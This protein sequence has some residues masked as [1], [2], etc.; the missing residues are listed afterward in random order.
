MWS[1]SVA[2]ARR[3]LQRMRLEAG[4][5]A[6]GNVAWRE[7]WKHGVVKSLPV[8]RNAARL[9][10]LCVARRMP[11]APRKTAARSARLS[12]SSCRCD[13]GVGDRYAFSSH[14]CESRFIAS[15]PRLVFHLPRLPREEEADRKAAR[16]WMRSTRAMDPESPLSSIDQTPLLIG[17]HC[18]A[19]SFM[20]I[21]ALTT[22][23]HLAMQSMMR[24]RVE[25]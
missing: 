25:A 9:L 20:M 13:C 10:L 2:S 1:G 16:A 24:H 22:S 19:K 4:W 17:A 8:P 18:P 23:M 5:V 11:L 12:P 3:P 15:R 7:T 6:P 21:P 14:V